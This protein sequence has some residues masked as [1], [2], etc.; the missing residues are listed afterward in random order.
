MPK[1]VID[2]GHGGRDP[3]AVYEGRQ[4]KDD[5]L[6]MAL[7]VGEILERNGVDVVYTRTTDVYNSP[8]EKA[9][10]ANNADADYFLS[11]HRNSSEIPGAGTGIQ[12]LVYRDDGIR[13]EMA[14]NINRELTNLGFRDLG[15][16]ERPNLVVLRR[17]ENPAVL[18]EVGFINNQEDNALFDEQFNS[19]ADAI[20]D[21]VLETLEEDPPKNDGVLYRVQTGSY[22]QSSNANAELQQLLRQGFPAFVLYEDGL[23]K[24][25]VGAFEVLNNAVRMEQTLRR[26]GY[27]TFITT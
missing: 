14:R 9:V 21:G 23:Y 13:A 26:A 2:P 12:T 15:V 16:E 17:T 11:I 3:G 1:I 18:V 22:R 6:A 10:I 5:V 24:V 7:A 27:N 8:Y 20:A 25:Q 4:E 19:V